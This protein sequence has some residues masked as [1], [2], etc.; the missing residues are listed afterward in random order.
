[1]HW[2][3][4]HSGILTQNC[5]GSEVT[6]EVHAVIN[7]PLKRHKEPRVIEIKAL[8][9][10]DYP[11][12]KQIY[13]QGIDTGDATFETTTKDWLEWDAQMLP[14]CRFVATENESILGW[15]AL[16]AASDRC[17]YRGV[18]EISVYV[19]AEA[20]GKGIGHSLLASLITCSE[21]NGIWTLQAG[22]FSENETS[23][24][25]HLKHGFRLLG[26]RQRLGELNGRWRDVTFL[27]RRSQVVGI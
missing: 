3:S 7:S 10:E 13:Q 4:K 14:C 1:M 11:R 2:S 24:K 25:L 23:L 16:S 15:A 8:E 22:I 19:A 17:A 20:R 26:V 27:E 6:P 18:A 9:M 12:V 21:D 5:S